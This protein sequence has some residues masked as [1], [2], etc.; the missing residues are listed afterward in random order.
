MLTCF[1]MKQ[2]VKQVLKRRYILEE[3]YYLMNYKKWRINCREVLAKCKRKILRTQKITRIS[4]VNIQNTCFNEVTNHNIW[5][6]ELS[7]NKKVNPYKACIYGL[8]RD[9][10]DGVW[11]D[12]GTKLVF[13]E[14]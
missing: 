14:V 7:L 8:C 12:W 6:S 5:V 3:L 11:Y 4:R 9:F 1:K 10:L 2:N 13:I